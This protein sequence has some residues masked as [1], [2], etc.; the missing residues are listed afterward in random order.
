M[1]KYSFLELFLL[2]LDFLLIYM[3]TF[4]SIFFGMLLRKYFS[5]QNRDLKDS[6]MKILQSGYSIFKNDNLK[7]F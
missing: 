4:S 6:E 3:I 5:I 2:K 1:R 7:H